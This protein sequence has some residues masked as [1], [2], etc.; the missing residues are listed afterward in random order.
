MDRDLTSKE[1]AIKQYRERL[2]QS[3]HEWYMTDRVSWDIPIRDT[4]SASLNE[5]ETIYMRD[6]GNGVYSFLSSMRRD[7]CSIKLISSSFFINNLICRDSSVQGYIDIENLL[8]GWTQQLCFRGRLIFEVEC[9]S[10]KE[11][12]T[13]FKFILR[14]LDNTLCKLTHKGVVYKDPNNKVGRKVIIPNSKCVIIDFPS[15]LGGFDEFAKVRDKVY[16]LGDKLPSELAINGN[17]FMEHVNEWERKFN[18]AVLK[19]GNRSIKGCNEYY[20]CLNLYRF[21]KSSLLCLLSCINGLKQLLSCFNEKF[22]E[23]VSIEITNSRCDLSS[24]EEME[25]KFKS[26]QISIENAR[27]YIFKL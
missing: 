13:N 27:N 1:I 9:L 10:S 25:N 18:I 3:D 5:F 21:H 23:N 6:M 4:V 14:R 7:T 8:S 15:E 24:F 16:A 20:Q 12:S 17:N 19:W 11:D 2:K 26:G 22:N